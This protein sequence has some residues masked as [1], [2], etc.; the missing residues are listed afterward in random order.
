MTLPSQPDIIWVTDEMFTSHPYLSYTIEIV[1]MNR[2]LI[3]PSVRQSI[4]TNIK[5]AYCQQFAVSVLPRTCW[6]QFIVT[7]GPQKAAEMNESLSLVFDNVSS[8]SIVINAGTQ[9]GSLLLQPYQSSTSM[10]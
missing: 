2:V 5:I 9:L 8:H 3:P 4:L 10:S 7:T 1:A 6:R